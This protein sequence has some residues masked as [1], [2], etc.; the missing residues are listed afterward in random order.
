MSVELGLYHC[1]ILYV[2]TVTTKLLKIL[3]S[4]I[5]DLNGTSVRITIGTKAVKWTVYAA[6]GASHPAYIE[7]QSSSLTTFHVWIDLPNSIIIL[8]Q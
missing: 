5:Y 7:I 6:Q 8:F 2:T 3:W 1:V 4:Y